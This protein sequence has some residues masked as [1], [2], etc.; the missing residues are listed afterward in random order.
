MCLAT[1][2]VCYG[3]SCT[4]KRFLGCNDGLFFHVATQ[5]SRPAL[6][7]HLLSLCSF[8]HLTLFPGQCF[9]LHP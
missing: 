1:L 2:S 7:Q 4:V 9:F 8:E 3:G 5:R 6:L